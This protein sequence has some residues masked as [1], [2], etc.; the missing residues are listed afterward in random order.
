MGTFPRTLPKAAF[1]ILKYSCLDLLLLH[2]PDS[3]ARAS[4]RCPSWAGTSAGTKPPHRD[5]Q[6]PLSSHQ[7]AGAAS[8]TLL[9]SGSPQN[10]LECLS[11]PAPTALL[12]SQRFGKLW[13][14]RSEFRW[15][16]YPWNILL[17]NQFRGTERKK[18]NLQFN[19]KRNP[20]KV[21]ILQA[22]GIPWLWVLHPC[23]C[24]QTSKTDPRGIIWIINLNTT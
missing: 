21:M 10:P 8:S 19:H 16:L 14:P 17:T 24:L 18:M 1:N 23:R 12:K 4:P 3:P 9:N 2:S 11:S 15:F 7:T 6:A 22:S 20:P 5:R 13:L